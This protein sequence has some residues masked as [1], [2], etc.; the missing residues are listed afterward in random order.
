MNA[1]ALFKIGYGLYI[2]SAR[3]GDI[4]NGCVVNTVIQLTNTPNRLGI[5][6][7]KQ[8]KTHDMILA[9]GLFNVSC[10]TVETEFSTIRNFGF[11]SGK[12]A[13][14]FENIPS[15]RSSN[16]LLYL[17]NSVNAFLSGKVT[18]T[19]DLGSHTL[20]IADFTDG[21]V[22]GTAESLTY[23]YYFANIKPKAAIPPK[24]VGYR[25]TICNYIYEGEP[26]PADFIC[27]IC[28]HGAADF[29]KL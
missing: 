28:K 20:F 3:E 22:L 1:N 15:N 21:E 18:S 23:A 2:L 16:G 14:K 5:A 19:V 6:V 11:Q 24:Q 8:N 26:L 27:P 13:D 17:A 29:V 9:S 25:C 7:N 4:D 12:T 10:L